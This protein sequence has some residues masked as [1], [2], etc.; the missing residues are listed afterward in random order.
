MSKIAR[1][2][3]RIDRLIDHPT[4]TY[5]CLSVA[6]D[7]YWVLIR[8]ACGL[9]SID[10]ERNSAATKSN[11]TLK[12]PKPNMERRPSA[13]FKVVG[14]FAINLRSLFHFLSYFVSL[15]KCF[16]LFLGQKYWVFHDSLIY[17][18]F[19]VIYDR[20]HD[21]DSLL[22]A[23]PFFN[24]RGHVCKLYRPKAKCTETAR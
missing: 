1:P 13:Q 16:F 20:Q 6:Y 19:P 2:N 14:F 21:V 15:F 18:R 12:E 23:H 10:Q 24:T 4:E 3:E 8:H 9:M 5:T 17:A 7:K 11:S 22:S